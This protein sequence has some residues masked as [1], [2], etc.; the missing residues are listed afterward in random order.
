MIFMKNEEIE[1]NEVP[2]GL[3]ERAK[4]FLDMSRRAY[5]FEIIAIE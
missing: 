4:S 2:G 3:A 1:A 5:N